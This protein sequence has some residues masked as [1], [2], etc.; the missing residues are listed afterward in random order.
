VR[1]PLYATRRDRA[2]VWLG[3]RKVAEKRGYGL[4]GIDVAIAAGEGPR[5]LVLLVEGERGKPS[6]MAKLAVVRER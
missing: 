2:E 3:G 4:G 1:T 5:R 6:G